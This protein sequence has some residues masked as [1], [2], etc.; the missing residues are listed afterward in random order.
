M[1]IFRSSFEDERVFYANKKVQSN[2]PTII[3]FMKLS[4]VQFVSGE[5]VERQR[6]EEE[7]GKKERK[8]QQEEDR[9]FIS[10]S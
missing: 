10:H 3:D 5:E 1:L 9:G 8:R 7:E 6:K 4:F 2:N